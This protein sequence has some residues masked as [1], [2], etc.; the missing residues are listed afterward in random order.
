MLLEPMP[1]HWQLRSL[2]QWQLQ[3]R[4]HLQ[5]LQERH[6]LSTSQERHLLSTSQQLPL[7]SRTSPRQL[8]HTQLPLQCMRHHPRHTRR[9]QCM[10]H[11]PRH[12]R[13]VSLTM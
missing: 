10:R 2:H 3:C 8:R 6:L 9:R 7:L 13:R 11:R 4:Y 12:T 1:R 5:Q